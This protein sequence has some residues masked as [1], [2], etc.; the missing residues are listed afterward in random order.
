MCC[1]LRHRDQD[2]KDVQQVRVTE[3]R[4]G[5]VLSKEESVKGKLEG[6]LMNE[7]NETERKVDGAAPA[8][9]RISKV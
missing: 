6:E 4:D 9:P 7:E 3:G 5:N 8:V 1:L 2:G